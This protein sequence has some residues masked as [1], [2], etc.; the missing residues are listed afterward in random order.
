MNDEPLFWLIGDLLAYSTVLA[1]LGLIAWVFIKSYKD[2]REKQNDS[3][4]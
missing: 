3:I 2:K 4:H 1:V